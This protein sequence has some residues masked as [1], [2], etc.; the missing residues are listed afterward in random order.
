M[1][2]GGRSSP[3]GL[4][5]RCAAEAEEQED[6][7]CWMGPDGL[8]GKPSGC[9]LPEGAFARAG[10]GHREGRALCHF[11]RAPL[12]QAARDLRAGQRVG[13]QGLQ[14]PACGHFARAGTSGGLA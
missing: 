13:L 3:C 7:G 12:R 9:W 1:A 2:G 8:Q 11:G 14:G 5:R 10:P 4:H 6:E